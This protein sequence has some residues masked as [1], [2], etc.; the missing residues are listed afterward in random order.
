MGLLEK[1]K[2]KKPEDPLMVELRRI[3]KL[4]GGDVS[5]RRQAKKYMQRSHNLSGRQLV[6][7]RKST[8]RAYKQMALDAQRRNQ[9]DADIITADAATPTHEAFREEIPSVAS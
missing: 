7:L 5:S 2:I 9:Q 8:K 6:K 3:S 1:L 4:C